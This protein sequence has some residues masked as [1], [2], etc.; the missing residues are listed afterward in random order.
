MKNK[1]ILG[2][3]AALCMGV[4]LCVSSVFAVNYWYKITNNANNNV[5]ST[6]HA[7]EL[8]TTAT[9]GEAEFLYPGG[10]VTFEAFTV[11]APLWSNDYIATYDPADATG[12]AVNVA[13]PKFNLEVTALE[14]TAGESDFNT[15]FTVYIKTSVTNAWAAVDLDGTDGVDQLD[16]LMY[17][18][19]DVQHHND[20][21]DFTVQIR[22]AFNKDAD[23]K[24]A[25]NAL[26]F[27]VG[28]VAYDSNGVKI[29]AG[30][31]SSATVDPINP[32]A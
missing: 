30:S 3:L 20:G 15:Q 28:L 23:V 22:I 4:I 31:N 27:T 29:A 21:N 11:K 10:L 17:L 13:G 19:K 7:I 5:V 16:N 6:G 25:E 12:A 18:L 9:N 32:L 24:Y 8:S 26:T 2:A 14:V 1:K